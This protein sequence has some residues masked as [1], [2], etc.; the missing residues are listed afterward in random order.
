MLHTYLFAGHLLD[1]E[2]YFFY[3]LF[4]NVLPLVHQNVKLR[5]LNLTKIE[6]IFEVLITQKFQIIVSF[7]RRQE[8][9]VQFTTIDS[10]EKVGIREKLPHQ[11]TLA[12]NLNR[13]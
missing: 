5:I 4:A 8:C 13:S 9:W 2:S 11:N 12:E 3:K 10:A 1:C 6:E 7:M